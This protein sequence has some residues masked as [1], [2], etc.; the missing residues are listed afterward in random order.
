MTTNIHIELIDESQNSPLFAGV[1]AFPEVELVARADERH[2][3][4]RQQDSGARRTCQLHSNRYGL[5]EVLVESLVCQ[6]NS[7]SFVL[8]QGNWPF[9]RPPIHVS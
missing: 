5:I 7:D 6:Q 4:P 3:Q 8:F 1:H 9:D 2:P